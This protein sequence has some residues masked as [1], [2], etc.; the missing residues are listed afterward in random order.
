MEN[1]AGDK[2]VKIQIA[3]LP[4]LKIPQ[5]T[6]NRDSKVEAIGCFRDERSRALPDLVKN[7]RGTIDWNHME[8]T[9]ASCAKAVQAKGY[10]YFGLQFYG[11]CWSGGIVYDKYGVSPPESCWK[12]VGKQWANFVYKII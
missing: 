6:A 7:L 12:G 1:A 3:F 9:V 4:P 5:G 8:R 10:K 11:E 2:L